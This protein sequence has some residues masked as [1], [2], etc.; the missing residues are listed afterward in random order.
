MFLFVMSDMRKIIE[1]NILRVKLLLSIFSDTF[2]WSGC[3]W[4]A[5]KQKKDSLFE[6]I[7]WYRYKYL[8][9]NNPRIIIDS[10]W[11]KQYGKTVDWNNPRDLN[12]KIQ[13][14]ICF[15]DTSKW[16]KLADKY[17]VRKYVGDKGYDD[18][19]PKLYGVWD[20]VTKIDYDKLPDKFVIK[21]NH[22]SGSFHL[23]DK[24]KGFDRDAINKDLNRHLCYK[25]GY[26][27][28][29]PHYNKIKPLIIAEE[30]LENDDSISSS[31]IDYKVWCFNGIPFTILVIY[32]R[33]KEY[34]YTNAYDLDWQVHPEWSNFSN[35][36]RDGE[37]KV[38]K[39]EKLPEML[40]IAGDLSK[41]FPQ[42][43]VDFY[44]LDNKIYFGEMT[45]T[46]ACG[47]MDYFSDD[48]LKEM[49]DK[50][51]L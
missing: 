16:V 19:L 42:V 31:I 22:D 26:R 48:F 17:L 50:V 5:T 29:E 13:W 36:Y 7:L 27:F 30:Y 6:K 38:S 33:H 39:P 1:T 49:G 28:C 24:R 45:F 51:V 25:F 21:C 12:E 8:V 14:L 20:D 23:I 18:M 10:I 4:L 3:L 43:R 15:G 46:S 2:D 37:G 9:D 34:M 41:G 11:K 40:K 32:N 44:I 47:R 35:H